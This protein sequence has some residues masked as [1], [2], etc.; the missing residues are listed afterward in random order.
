MEGKPSKAW[1][2]AHPG[3][4]APANHG[5]AKRTAVVRFRYRQSYV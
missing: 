5:E 1:L 4:E 2:A 3:I